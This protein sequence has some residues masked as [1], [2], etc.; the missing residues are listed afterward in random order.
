[1]NKNI[2]NY[3]PSNSCVESIVIRK[4]PELYNHYKLLE[5]KRSHRPEAKTFYDKPHD[6]GMYG[7]TRRRTRPWDNCWFSNKVDII[8]LTVEEA[9]KQHPQYMLWCYNNLGINWSVHTIKLL[10]GLKDK[11]RRMTMA[12]FKSLQTKTMNYESCI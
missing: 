12:D 6:Q 8:L 4:H 1:M 7:N 11:P 9:V 2:L 10:E 3:L 5:L